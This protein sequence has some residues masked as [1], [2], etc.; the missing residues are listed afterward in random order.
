[1]PASWDKTYFRVGQSCVSAH[2]PM[3]FL[4]SLS[5]LYF[6]KYWGEIENEANKREKKKNKILFKQGS[7]AS[8]RAGQYP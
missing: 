6:M 4:P 7:P 8:S 2:G 3:S 1:M 5:M